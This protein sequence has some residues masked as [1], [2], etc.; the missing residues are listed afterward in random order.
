M[1]SYRRGVFIETEGGGGGGVFE[2][3]CVCQQGSIS[4]YHSYILNNYFN[5][6]G[7]VQNDIDSTALLFLWKKICVRH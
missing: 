6:G 7:K 5:G 4:V 2:K 1:S 3:H